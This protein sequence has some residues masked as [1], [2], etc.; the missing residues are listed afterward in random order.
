ML[1]IKARFDGKQV[2]LPQ[3]VANVP[4]GNVIVVFEN[5]EPSDRE[6]RGW[7]KVQEEAFANVWNNDEDAVYDTL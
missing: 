1:A 4:P 5:E 2:I 3:E 6:I 7:M